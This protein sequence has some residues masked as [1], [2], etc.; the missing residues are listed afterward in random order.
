MKKTVLPSRYKAFQPTWVLQDS[1]IHQD[2]SLKYVGYNA[3]SD[4]KTR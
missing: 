1:K 4:C 3:E 2:V